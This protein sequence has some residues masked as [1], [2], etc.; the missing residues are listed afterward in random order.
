MAGKELP[1][2]ADRL[3]SKI[4]E[5][6]TSANPNATADHFARQM[7]GENTGPRAYADG[8]KMNNGNCNGCWTI[9]R[10]D[11]VTVSFRPGGKASKSTAETTATVDIGKSSAVE[12]L[13]GNKRRD[14]KVKFPQISGKKQ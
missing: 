3:N 7:A 5:M 6:P 4:R 13:T 10:A 11:G 12:E 9:K 14:I 8:S 1:G 2:T